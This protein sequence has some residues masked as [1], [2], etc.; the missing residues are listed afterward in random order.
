MKRLFICLI[1]LLFAGISSAEELQRRGI[2][3]TPSPM[4]LDGTTVKPRNDAWSFSV[5]T[6]KQPITAHGTISSGTEICAPGVHTVTAGGAFTLSLAGFTS[7]DHGKTTIYATNW[8]A[9]VVTYPAAVLWAG[10]SEPTETAAGI[11]V[12]VF[13]ST[14]GGT[15]IYGFVSGADMQ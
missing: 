7:G 13:T 8:G 11:D 14:D 6:T 9:H 15:T 4:I 12:L 3:G 5:G 2:P 1:V 10:G